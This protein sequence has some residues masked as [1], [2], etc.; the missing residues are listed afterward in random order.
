MITR[1][2]SGIQSNKHGVISAIDEK[3]SH[4]STKPENPKN[5]LTH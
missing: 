1:I 3:I 5:A 4:L 2:K